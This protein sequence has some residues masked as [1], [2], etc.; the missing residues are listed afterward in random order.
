MQWLYPEL[1]GEDKL[2]MM[3]G[4]LHIEMCFRSTIG[5]WLDGSGWVKISVKSNINTPGRAES[6]LQGKQ[7]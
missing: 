1:Y 5:D 7:V 4:A 2:L 3:M 6:M